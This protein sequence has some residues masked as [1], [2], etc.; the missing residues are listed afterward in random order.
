MFGKRSDK[1]KNLKNLSEKEI[2]KQLYGEYLK[3]AYGV[4]VMDSSFLVKEKEEHPIHEKLDTKAKKELNAEL[5]GLKSEFKRLQGEVNRLSKEKESLDRSEIWFRPPL[6]KTKHLVIIGSVVVLL[7][8]AAASFFTIRF[9]VTKVGHKEEVKASIQAPSQPAK[10]KSA[11]A[12]PASVK[13]PS[14]KAKE[15]KP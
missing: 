15:S 7:A 10:K 14:K 11:A 8:V 13:K 2:Q 4:E 6:L 3:G 9:F 5:E 1:G 12:K